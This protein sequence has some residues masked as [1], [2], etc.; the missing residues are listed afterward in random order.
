MRLLNI[1]T[2]RF[3]GMKQMP[4][5]LG[6]LNLN[7]PETNGETDSNY[8]AR[9]IPIERKRCGLEKSLFPTRCDDP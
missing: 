9:I 4:A 1:L 2:P 6:I 5:K 3:E 7:R 8:H